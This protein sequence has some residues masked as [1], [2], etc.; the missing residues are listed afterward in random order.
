MMVPALCPNIV[1]DLRVGAWNVQRPVALTRTLNLVQSLNPAMF[2]DDDDLA[3]GGFVCWLT[4]EG[5]AA[6]E[7][8]LGL[9]DD[10][11][12]ETAVQTMMS[13]LVEP[14]VDDSAR[15]VVDDRKLHLAQT[16][17]GRNLD[18]GTVRDELHLHF[19]LHARAG[20]VLT[21]M[22]ASMTYVCLR[23][24]P[25]I[26][27]AREATLADALELISDL[28]VHE[29]AALCKLEFLYVILSSP[30]KRQPGFG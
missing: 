14:E 24:K 15:E 8:G 3:G 27:R 13:S 26:Y 30:T 23:R 28:T 1:T 21:K 9:D 25:Q 10:Y 22:L 7:G 5:G 2:A 20:R 19:V 17:S 11:A 4:V 6:G 29:R 12:G 18:D 16:K